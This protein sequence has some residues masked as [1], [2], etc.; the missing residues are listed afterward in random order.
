LRCARLPSDLV[1]TAK[2]GVGTVLNGVHR[3][4]GRTYPVIRTGCQTST[5][6]WTWDEA[7]FREISRIKRS[8]PGEQD[9]LA[10]LKD[11]KKA[12]DRLAYLKTD[13]TRRTKRNSALLRAMEAFEAQTWTTFRPGALD[14]QTDQFRGGATP[15]CLTHDRDYLR[16]NGLY[17]ELNPA[18]RIGE[19]LSG[20][21]Q[22]QDPHLARVQLDNG[23]LRKWVGKRNARAIAGAGMFRA[24]S[25]RGGFNQLVRIAA[26]ET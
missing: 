20:A 17:D 23:F 14:R 24:A 7:T 2:L 10:G 8:V 6:G 12:N 16:A 1:E 26:L 3:K 5:A 19:T 9:D 21:K 4:P 18:M 13:S 15:S 22:A 11:E 25:L